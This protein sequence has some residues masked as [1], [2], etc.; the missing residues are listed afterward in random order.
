MPTIPAARN[1]L[2]ILRYLGERAAP[3]RASSIARDLALPRSSVY[4]LLRVLMDEGFVIHYPEHRTYG[5]STL[6][7]ELGAAPRRSA[8]LARLAAPLLERLVPRAPLPVVAHLALLS[9]ADVIYLAR[10]QGFRAPT[11]VTNT[12]V[13]LP[14]HLTATGR[15][16]LAALP[17][18]QVR[19]LY[20]DRGSL[21]RRNQ[22]GPR[23]LAQLEGILAE[24]RERGWARE[25]GEITED[26][27]SAG[28]T[29]LDTTGYPAAAIGLTF[30]STA[31][32]ASHWD[33]LGDAV[34][35]TAREVTARLAGRH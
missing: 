4:Q 3:A 31:A 1:A 7:A 16:L 35:T 8:Q 15:S 26:Y 21:I 23:T 11:T 30:R 32:S 9:G 14:A 20:P 12:G 2:G 33:A 25:D 34:V 28:A 17:P 6:M 24:T 5:P 19:A 18:G 27:A 29:A 13:R 22:R 10:V